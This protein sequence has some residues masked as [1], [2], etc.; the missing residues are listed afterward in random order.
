MPFPC[1]GFV[2]QKDH[3]LFNKR[4]HLLSLNPA[5]VANEIFVRITVSNIDGTLPRMLHLLLLH[6]P[7]I[8]WHRL[9]I[10]AS[11]FLDAKV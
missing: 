9:F 10:V 4:W 8:S 1:T 11:R 3:L 2:G 5:L 7:Y 6:F